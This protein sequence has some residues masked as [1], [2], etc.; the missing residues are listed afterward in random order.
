MKKPKEP[1][2]EIAI[3]GI[4]ENCRYWNAKYVPVRPPMS[5]PTA[6][7]I[8]K[9]MKKFFRIAVASPKILFILRSQRVGGLFFISS[10]FNFSK[11]DPRPLMPW[12]PSPLFERSMEAALF[13]LP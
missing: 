12:R 3:I 11:C 4:K 9:P 2:D 8:I 13:A 5:A 10:S 1:P 7:P 6:P